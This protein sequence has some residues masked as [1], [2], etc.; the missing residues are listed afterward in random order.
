MPKLN[1]EG[2]GFV[3]LLIIFML[4]IFAGLKEPTIFEFRICGW[5]WVISLLVAGIFIF[6]ING[7]RVTF[8]LVWWLPFFL[9][10]MIMSDL[11]QRD[12]IYR[13]LIFLCP[14]LLGIAASRFYLYNFERVQIIYVFSVC[15]IWLLYICTVLLTDERL[16]IDIYAIAGP[17]MTVVLLSIIALEDPFIRKFKLYLVLLLCFV[18]CIFTDARMPILLIIFLFL[19][20]IKNISFVSRI[21]MFVVLCFLFF[22]LFRYSFVQDYIFRYGEGDIIDLLSLDPNLIKTSGRLYAWPIY[23]GEIMKQPWFGHGSTMSVDFGNITFIRWSHPHNEYI[24]ILF[25]Y[26]FLG[27]ILF[28]IPILNLAYQ[29]FKGTRHALTEETKFLCSVGLWGIIAMFLLAITGNVLMYVAWYGNLLFALI[30]FGL[31]RFNFEQS[32]YMIKNNE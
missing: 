6:I 23:W 5:V 13:F 29:C 32:R 9:Y 11:S 21:S 22:F 15:G 16:P 17:P 20:R 31:S 28:L 7:N 1:N 30:G 19:L 8:P 14:I 25:D 27:A 12:D 10:I 24:R 18:F 4:S 3:L 26:G 2:Y